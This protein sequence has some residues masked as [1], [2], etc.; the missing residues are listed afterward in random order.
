MKTLKQLVKDCLTE[1]DGI[2]YCGAKVAAFLALCTYFSMVGYAVHIAHTLDVG[3]FGTGLAATLA[4]CGVLIAGK[5][6]S[7]KGPATI[8]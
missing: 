6:F 8:V 5:Q 7:Q 4:G 3:A 1:D 2:H